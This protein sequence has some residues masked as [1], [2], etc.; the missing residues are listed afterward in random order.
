MRDKKVRSGK[1]KKWKKIIRDEGK[2]LIR[3]KRRLYG[4]LLQSR[5]GC[6]KEYKRA[7]LEIKRGRSFA[8]FAFFCVQ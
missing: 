8:T 2:A 3:V 6:N 4:S 7:K 1:G 5:F